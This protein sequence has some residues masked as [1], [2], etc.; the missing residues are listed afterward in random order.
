[1]WISQSEVMQLP[2]SGSAWENVRDTAYGSW[3]RPNLLNQD[4]NHAINTL[5]GALASV[6]LEDES[7]RATVRDA[8]MAAKRTADESNEWQTDNGVLAAGRQIGAYVIA[9]DLIDLENYDPVFDWDF[10]DWL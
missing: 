4:S 10:R 8:I 9:A 5:A 6:R 2:T 1:M 7:L 3:G